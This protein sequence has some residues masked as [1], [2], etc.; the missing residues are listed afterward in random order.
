MSSFVSNY[1][2][3]YVK[4][5]L[6]K[7]EHDAKKYILVKVYEFDEIPVI[8]K[9]NYNNASGKL[10]LRNG[11]TY[12]RSYG[13]PETIE[14]PSQNEMR[15]I[16]D[17]A[18]EKKVRRFLQTSRRVGVPL[19]SGISDAERFKNQIKDILTDE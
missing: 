19:V 12:T 15:E 8:C 13:K 10:I 17:I 1:A 2:D 6:Y 18:T 5:D 7:E 9:R 14:V 11:A 4:F 16:L 3:P